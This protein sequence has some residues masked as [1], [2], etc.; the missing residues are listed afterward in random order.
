MFRQVTR[1]AAV[2]ALTAVVATAAWAA[3]AS[4]KWT[5]TQRRQQ[6]DVTVN[7]ELKQDGEKL[8]GAI[9]GENGNKTEIKDGSVK[10]G[11][12]KFSVTR[13]RNGQDFTIVYSGKLDG[14][15]IKGNTTVNFNG[16]ERKRDWTATRA[17]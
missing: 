11:M 7:C 13:S 6:N 3:D 4:G 8:T 10:D 16:Q 12:V 17:K 2:T 1:W 9:I 15:T 5:W 14:D